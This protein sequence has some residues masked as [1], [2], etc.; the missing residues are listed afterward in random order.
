MI[1]HVIIAKRALAVRILWKISQLSVPKASNKTVN[2]IIF[3]KFIIYIYNFIES[4]YPIF[5]L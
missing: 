5:L 3:F 1:L 4:L 2:I